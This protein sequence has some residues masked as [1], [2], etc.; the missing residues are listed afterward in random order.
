MTFSL[1]LKIYKQW[2]NKA[3]LYCCYAQG[4]ILFQ[5]RTLFHSGDTYIDNINSSDAD[6]VDTIASSFL[7][8]SDNETVASPAFPCT[9]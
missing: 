2:F 8:I 7:D 6:Y 5:K 9:I 1:L 4:T 3:M